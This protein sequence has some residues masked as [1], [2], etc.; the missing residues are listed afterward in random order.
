MGPILR[1]GFNFKTAEPL[2]ADS[3]LVRTKTP[4][5]PGTNLSGLKQMK[6]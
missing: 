6:H 4:G 3:L 2:L 1:I 5:V